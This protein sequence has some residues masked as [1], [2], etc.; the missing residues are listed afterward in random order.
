VDEREDTVAAIDEPVTVLP[1]DARL[2]QRCVEHLV[3]RAA[4][5]G[6]HRIGPAGG[7]LDVEG[8]YGPVTGQPGSRERL[9]PR[10]PARH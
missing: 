7:A 8:D 10:E 2:E 6:L 3:Q 5:L 4:E 1:V 9:C